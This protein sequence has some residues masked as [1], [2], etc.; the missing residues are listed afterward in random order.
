MQVRICFRT[1]MNCFP[2]ISLLEQDRR[3]LCDLKKDTIKYLKKRG[4]VFCFGHLMWLKYDFATT[5]FF[6]TCNRYI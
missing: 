2:I 1:K 6:I 3:K 5:T 4:I